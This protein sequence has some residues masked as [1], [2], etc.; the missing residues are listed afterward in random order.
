MSSNELQQTINDM[1]VRGKGILATDESLPT[2]EKR[3]ASI[4]TENTLEN[5]RQYRNMI[6]TAPGIEHYISGVILFEETLK[7]KTNSGVLFPEYLQNLGVV[8]GIKVDKGTESFE[9]STIEKYTKGLDGLGE[10]L[11]VYKKLGARFAKWRAVY[12][13]SE[14][15]PSDKLIQRNAEDLASYAHV[16]QEHGIV[17]VVEPEVLMDGEYST[18]SIDQCAEVTEK[19]LTAVFA[20]LAKQGVALGHIILK[21]NMVISGKD[22]KDRVGTEEVAQKT[23]SVLKKTV[24]SEVPSIN[25]LSGGQGPEEATTNLNAI[26]ALGETLPWYVSFSYGRG[27]QERALNVWRGKQENLAA[28][29]EAFIEQARLN[30]LATEGKL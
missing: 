29:Q 12:A 13:I 28:A 10:R 4:G 22:A 3:L 2:A 21:P 27:L 6:L 8:P 23:V 7:Q 11:D 18:H 16:C 17:P 26:N 20:A 30:G 19:V 25:F 14:T 15:T 1:V 5:R 24:P 9:G